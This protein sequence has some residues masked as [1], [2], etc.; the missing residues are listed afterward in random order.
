MDNNG[1]TKRC[2]PAIKALI[3][4]SKDPINPSTNS[5]Y[6]K[7]ATK[8]I[9]DG[10]N[11][12][13]THCGAKKYTVIFTSGASESNCMIIRSTVESYIKNKKKKPHIITS[14]TEH[15]SVLECCKSLNDMNLADITYVAPSI[16]GCINPDF[17][18]KSIR[19]N[20]A[21]ITIMAANN[22]LGCI[23]NFKA[24]GEISHAYKI[25]FHSDFV[26]IFGKMRINLPK[27]NVDAIS[28]SF[29]KL[30][31]PTGCGLLII[32]NDFINGYD[33]GPQIYGTQQG[34]LRGGTQNVPAIASSIAAMKCTFKNRTKK[35]ERLRAL[36]IYILSKLSK[37]F[38]FGKY[39]S[40]FDKTNKKK[41]LELVLLGQTNSKKS[42]NNT[43]LLSIAKNNGRRFCNAKLKKYLDSKRIIVSVG[44]ACNTKSKNASHVIQSI[45]APDVIKQGIIRISLSDTTTKKEIDEFIKE[46]ITGIKIQL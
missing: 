8:M 30:Y 21:L 3:K 10:I 13:K 28:V 18:K 20:T 44:S 36:R 12:I 22:E 40:Y 23:N 45:R 17:I 5:V 31:G 27:N 25:P 33:L 38:K 37:V 35:N 11:Y 43:I 6:G 1:T 19:P 9:N 26:Q 16:T 46:F 41:D 4:W 7:S 39:S 15:K 24:I 14:L 42:L 32:N 2:A 29:H 34:G